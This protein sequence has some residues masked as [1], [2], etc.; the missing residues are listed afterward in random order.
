MILFK[1]AFRQ[2]KS[3]NLFTLLNIFGLAV[4]LAACL[5]VYLFIKDEYSFDRQNKDADHIYRIITHI[6][7]D[8]GSIV[9][10]PATPPALAAA[11][12][13]T[14]P[15]LK[16]VVRLFPPAAGWG[17][18]F[19]V[20]HGDKQFIEDNIYRADSS[21]FD[22]FTVSFLNGN[23][24][25]A[26]SSP[27]GIV[28][29]QSIAKK[30][31]GGDNPIGKIMNVDDWEPHQVT[32][33]IKDFPDNVHFK[34][35]ML[36]SLQ[37][38]DLGGRLSQTWGWNSFYTYVRLQPGTPIIKFDKKINQIFRDNQPG[39]KNTIT[40]QALTSIHLHSDLPGELKPNSDASYSFIFAIVCLFILINACINYINFS[41]ASASFRAKEIG[42]RKISGAARATLFYQLLLEAVLSSLLA[43]LVALLL[44]FLFLPAVNQ[45]TGKQLALTHGSD[46]S[47]LISLFILS[48]LTGI[49][50]GCY[51]AFYLASFNPMQ[52]LK[53]QQMPGT[54]NVQLRKLLVFAQFFISVTLIIGIITVYRQVDFMQ[55]ANGGLD[56]DHIIIVNDIGFLNSDERT[57]LRNELVKNSGVQ[58]VAACDGV[59]G[60]YNWSRNVRLKGVQNSQL[61]N[62]LSIDN[63]FIPAFEI[64]I[65]EGRNFSAAYPADTADA[66]ILNETAVKDLGIATPV[67]GKQIVWNQN[68]KTGDI[69]YATIRGVVK[70]FYFTSMKNAVQPFAFS[71]RNNRQW[72]YAIKIDGKD[73]AGTIASIKNTWDKNIK[74]RPFQ[75]V[76]L[77]ETYAKLYKGE[78]NFK[79][80]FS[81]TAV[82]AI[83]K[84]CMGILSLSMYMMKRR[85]KEISIRKVLGA[86][87]TSI[88]ALLSKEFI[89]LIIAASL[90]SF[91][92]SWW[93]ASSWLHGYAYRI[94]IS[95]WVFPL[96]S[97]ALLIVALMTISFH[98]IKASTTNPVKSL[99]NE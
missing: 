19:Y 44:A 96:S 3:G 54:R 38:L 8:D 21:F 62:F 7:N 35:D 2:L 86:T 67:I 9:T 53:N 55:H 34:I 92:V 6:K 99:R 20:R 61:I 82:L 5:V 32:A 24:A 48:L 47:T 16:A 97:L 50:A 64:R 94:N 66:V 79:T 71:R 84:A 23:A 74:S 18:R 29:T 14:S 27:N 81:Y 46:Y 13:K 75:Y 12:Q 25:T 15:E 65:K 17:N 40:T 52:A 28:L 56:K 59:P 89:T 91:P 78:R 68:D 42:I 26:L 80:I 30:Y 1:T 83:V 41:T 70:D 60:G 69:T 57:I 76:F 49:L 90:I 43:G 33:V 31:F 37:S 11:M 93:L 77:D 58:Y 10:V 36:V 72:E 87:S 45:I 98:T 51:P 63:D 4:G 95:W 73:V 88:A 39:S 85:T 22:V